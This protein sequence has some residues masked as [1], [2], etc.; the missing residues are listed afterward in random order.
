MFLVLKWILEVSLCTIN[1]MTRVVL[2]EFICK[3]ICCCCVFVGYDQILF[4]LHV[5]Q[6]RPEKHNSFEW[7]T[8]TFIEIATYNNKQSWTNWCTYTNI[9]VSYHSGSLEIWTKYLLIIAMPHRVLSCTVLFNIKATKMVSIDCYDWNWDS[10]M[11]FL[12]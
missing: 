9:A 7:N 4:F 6:A 11:A 2:T 3:A 8:T 5:F 1:I 12:M 10:Y